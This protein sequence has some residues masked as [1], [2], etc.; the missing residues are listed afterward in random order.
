[1]QMIRTYLNIVKASSSIH[2]RA[3]FTSTNNMASSN[4]SRPSIHSSHIEEIH[5][6]PVSVIQ[7]PI[8]SLLD[9]AKVESLMQT[10]K[11]NNW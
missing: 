9:E 4:E 10:Y 11:V 5:E 2:L 8:P 6:V 3:F 1:M 7:R